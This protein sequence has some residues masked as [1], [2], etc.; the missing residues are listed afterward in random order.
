MSSLKISRFYNDTTWATESEKRRSSSLS[1]P[2]FRAFCQEDHS[3][4]HEQQ[5]LYPLAAK[6]QKPR[7]KKR[8]AE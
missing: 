3:Q 1:A 4:Q 2:P 6:H 8:N 5:P 7:R